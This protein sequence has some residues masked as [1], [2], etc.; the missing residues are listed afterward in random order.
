MQTEFIMVECDV[1]C[2]WDG[3]PPRYR[4]YVNDE[5]FTE[6]TWLWK[7][8]YLSENFQIQASPGTYQIRYEPLDGATLTL[9]NWR[10]L[11]GPAAINQHGSLTVR[12]LS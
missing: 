3:E 8:E 6:R 1:H 10:V 12:S 2:S 4:A 7:N 5:L 9:S 11:A